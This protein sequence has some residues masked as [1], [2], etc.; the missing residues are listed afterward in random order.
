MLAA[1]SAEDGSM[2]LLQGCCHPDVKSEDFWGPKGDGLWGLVDKFQ[3]DD[4]CTE[5]R[6]RDLIWKAS[7][8]ATGITFDI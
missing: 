1:Q 5:K 2:P 4:L 8:K 3:P 6:A 7:E